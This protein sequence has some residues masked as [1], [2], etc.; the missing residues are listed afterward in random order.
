MITGYEIERYADGVYVWAINHRGG[1]GLVADVS[2]DATL[3]EL[4]QEFYEV[5]ATV[6]DAPVLVRDSK[7]TPIKKCQLCGNSGYFYGDERAGPCRCEHG[8]NVE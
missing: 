4:A 2:K 1:K 3:E 8:K 7:S 6:N 5:L